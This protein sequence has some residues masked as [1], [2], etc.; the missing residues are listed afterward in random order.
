[1]GCEHVNL[2]VN[3][4]QPLAVLLSMRLASLISEQREDIDAIGLDEV[5]VQSFGNLIDWFKNSREFKIIYSEA[6]RS[7]STS[8]TDREI[9]ILKKYFAGQAFQCM[10]H[11]YLSVTQS[12]NTI[13]LS[14][15]RTL[16]YF[17]HHFQGMTTI[18]YPFG[19][20]SLDRFPVPDGLAV[21]VEEDYM[22]TV[23]WCEYT[24]NGDRGNLRD[25]LRRVNLHK[26]RLACAIPNVEIIF[27]TPKMKSVPRVLSTPEVNHFQMPFSHKEFR[28]YFED[29]FSH[30]RSD[31]FYDYPTLD[32]IQEF[33]R[34]RQAAVPMHRDLELMI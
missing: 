18:K 31:D 17:Q 15:P 28:Q 1:M 21:E 23:G 12:S 20:D 14:P 11:T 33:A 5:D 30:Y 2:A 19:L 16:D 7:L 4:E 9:A 27:V 13:L 3:P 34:K 32:E 10:A 24:L 8:Q 26:K 29:I 25:K 22:V 6:V